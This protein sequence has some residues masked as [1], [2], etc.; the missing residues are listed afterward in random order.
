[1]TLSDMTQRWDVFC[2]VVDNFGDIG[3][4][5]RLARQLQSEH[6]LDIR[7]WVD[8]LQVAQRLIPSLTL[9]ATE[10]RVDGIRVMHWCADADFSDAAD[11]VIEAFACGLPPAYIAAMQQQQSR[12]VNLEYL[13]AETWAEDFHAKTSPQANGMVRHFYFPG[14]TQATGGLIRERHIPPV[15]HPPAKQAV[16]ACKVSLFCYPHAPIISLLS[17]IAEGKQPVHC[18][19]PST[20]ILPQVADFF[21]K[22]S[23]Q[24]GQMVS[25]GALT[26]EVLPFLSQADYDQLL[27]RCDINF[28]RGEDSWVRAI[29][30]GKPFI[31]QPY[32][33][34]EGAH[35]P[36]LK[37]FLA[38]HY[39]SMPITALNVSQA[40]HMAWQDTAFQ[41]SVWDDY[42][43]AW[44]S[45]NAAT[46]E[47][48]RTLFSQTDLA[49]KLVIFCNNL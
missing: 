35:I 27:T 33:Q 3:V 31:W 14:F 8:D 29:W 49:S 37:A 2:K 46:Q 7:L 6:Q 10:Q 18:Y 19:V 24:V 34:E 43:A 36:K 17:A 28:V 42:L 20:T 22:T 41:A 23:L 12:W 16:N 1:M 32:L 25:H 26:V 30:A 4:C 48:S 39:Q 44:S 13:T 45:I 15:L 5:W 21:G 11:M 47:A 38:Q 40:M 9:A